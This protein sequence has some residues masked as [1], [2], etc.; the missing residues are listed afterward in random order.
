MHIPDRV[1][2]RLAGLGVSSDQP[3]LRLIRD[4]IGWRPSERRHA[5]VMS[6]RQDRMN[7]AAAASFMA[8]IAS[9]PADRP[10]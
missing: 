8:R 4:L 10:V 3:Q 6:S 9:E 7:P 2:E 5:A 1:A